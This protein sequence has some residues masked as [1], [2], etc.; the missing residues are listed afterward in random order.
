[1]TRTLL[2]LLGAALA[3]GESGRDTS[4]TAATVVTT[5]PATATATEAAS[6]AP[7]GGTG[8][9]STTLD[10]THWRAFVELWGDHGIMGTVCAADYAPFFAEAVDIIDNTCDN[11]VPPV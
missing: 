2:V 4:A 6:E 3:C 7:T 11:F 1:M 8:D 9:I 5:A 10:G